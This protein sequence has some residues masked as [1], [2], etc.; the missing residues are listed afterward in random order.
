MYQCYGYQWRL[1]CIGVHTQDKC[2][3]ETLDDVKECMRISRAKFFLRGVECNI[4]V[5]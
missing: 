1:M 5:V 2:G 4:P 3:V